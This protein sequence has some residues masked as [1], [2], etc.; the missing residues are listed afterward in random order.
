[1]IHG[2]VVRPDFRVCQLAYQVVPIYSTMGDPGKIYGNPCAT[3]ARHPAVVSR[4][5][6]RTPTIGG[7]ETGDPAV[8]I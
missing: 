2:Y 7:A 6:G 5:R 4:T 3:M 1:M 8:Q